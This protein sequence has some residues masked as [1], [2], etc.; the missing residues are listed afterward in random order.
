MWFNRWQLPHRPADYGYLLENGNLLVGVRTGQSPVDFG[1]RG[2]LLLEMDWEGNIVWSYEE[3]TLHPDFCRMANGNTMVV[4]WELVPADLARR[5][6]G[7]LA[8]TKHSPRH[9]VGLLS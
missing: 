5:V 8:S 3:P 7:G 1:R 6:R 2:G 4:G 9:V